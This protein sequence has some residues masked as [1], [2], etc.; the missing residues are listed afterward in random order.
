M[1]LGGK[2]FGFTNTGQVADPSQ[3]PEIGT[4]IHRVKFYSLFLKR[5]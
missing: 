2:V 5:I 1:D 3:C 4:E